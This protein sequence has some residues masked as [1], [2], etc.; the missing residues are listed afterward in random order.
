MQLFDDGS[1]GQPLPEEGDDLGVGRV[2]PPG[3][4]WAGLSA[5]GCGGGV[6]DVGGGDTA[7]VVADRV[8]VADGV[9]AV[10]DAV[11]DA[12]GGDGLFAPGE[13]GH[14]GGVVSAAPLVVAVVE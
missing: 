5:A 1:V 6:G 9:V 8:H 14:P 4:V 2:D 3:G 11:G 12:A 7:G 10:G 13:D